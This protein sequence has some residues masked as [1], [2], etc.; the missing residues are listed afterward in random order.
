[1]AFSLDIQWVTKVEN[2]L[3][4]LLARGLALSGARRCDDSKRIQR[5]PWRLDY[6]AGFQSP[7]LFERPCP[8][9]NLPK[10]PLRLPG[11]RAHE[12]LG[13]GTPV[14]DRIRTGG[15]S[16]LGRSSQCRFQAAR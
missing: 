9:D 11:Y 10:H 15:T 3:C 16:T 7:E 5:L 4:A 6:R 2:F 13:R 1:M 12:C 8:Q 14:L